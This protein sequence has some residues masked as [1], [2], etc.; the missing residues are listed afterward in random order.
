MIPGARSVHETRAMGRSGDDRAAAR[1]RAL[2]AYEAMGSMVRPKAFLRQPRY[3]DGPWSGAGAASVWGFSQPLAAAVSLVRLGAL[4]AGTFDPLL[5]LLERYRIGGGYGPFPGDATR[6]FDDN[7][8]IG[9]DLVGVHLAT[10]R[11]DALDG[12][13]RVLAFLRHGEH[14]RGGV[15][16]VEQAGS[17]RN[18]CSTGPTA[19]L[20]LWV[21]HLTGDA[22]AL[23]FAE[24]CR[25][26]LVDTLQRDDRLYADNVDQTGRIDHGIFSYNQGTPVGT[27]VLFHRIT[28]DRAYLD[29]AVTAAVASLAHFGAE[30]RCWTHA[31]SFNAIWLRNLVMLDAVRPVPGLWELLDPYAE[32]LWSEGRNPSTGWFT[33]GG[34]GSYG[35]GGVLDQGGV[36]QILA[37]PAYPTELAAALV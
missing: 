4:D 21:H 11:D 14:P 9:L 24:R 8:W 37:L 19:Q 27:D 7:A 6:Y 34:I 2:V 31:P 28:G 17:P 5:E 23:A 13:V 16:W 30:D 20:A 29:H 26:F 25:A 12:A 15:R 36:A 3:L 18:T 10:G 33:E 1:E 32:R 35:R 22:D